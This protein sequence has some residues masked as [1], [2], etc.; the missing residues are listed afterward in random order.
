[1][2]RSE[3]L[4]A[5]LGPI[6][7]IS[8]PERTDRVTPSTARTPPKCFDTP[9]MVSC[10]SFEEMLPPFTSPDTMPPAFPRP[11]AG[12]HMRATMAGMMQTRVAEGNGLCHCRGLLLLPLLSPRPRRET[13]GARNLRR[14]VVK[15]GPSGNPSDDS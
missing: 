3:V 6:T 2:L 11:S 14:R 1:M 9:E 13:I 12:P 4:P 5:P 15:R 8:S 10:V 7:E